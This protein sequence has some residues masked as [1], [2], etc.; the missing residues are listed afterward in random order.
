MESNKHSNQKL[1]SKE[2]CELALVGTGSQ[3]HLD[4]IA[5]LVDDEELE[6][7]ELQA[8]PN[9]LGCSNHF[10]TNGDHGCSLCK[11]WLEGRIQ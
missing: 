5:M 4:K 8:R 7:R 11:G 9:S 3:V 6:L 2:K 1:P 10:T